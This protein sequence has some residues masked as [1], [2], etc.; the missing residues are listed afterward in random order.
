MSYDG[1]KVGDPGVPASPEVV[2]NRLIP[3]ER[4]FPSLLEANTRSDDSRTEE[5]QNV[6]NSSSA[7]GDDT[8]GDFCSETVTTLL[9]LELLH[10]VILLLFLIRFTCFSLVSR[11]SHQ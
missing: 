10:C 9:E 6:K 3:G 11:N 4:S 5:T 7:R 1:W 8:L 2:R